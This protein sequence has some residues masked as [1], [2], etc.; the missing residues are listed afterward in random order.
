MGLFLAMSG[1]AQTTSSAVEDCLRSYASSR[2]GEITPITGNVEPWEVLILA[3]SDRHN[4]TVHYPCNF[5]F[6]DEASAYLSRSLDRPVFSFHIHD[7]DLWM[8]ILFAS[9]EAVDH[10]NPIPDYWDDRISPAEREL[11]AGDTRMVARN[12]SGVSEDAVR[13]YLVRW[14]LVDNKPS[15]AYPDDIFGFNDS[16]Q[17]TDFMRRIG[18]VYPIDDTGRLLGR[19]YRFMVPGG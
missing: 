14:D 7:D 18:L 10:F 2:G 9:G 15:K 13:N 16:W 3:D 8:Y 17:V 1:I 6:W 12:W 19:T 11:W 5:M 4:V